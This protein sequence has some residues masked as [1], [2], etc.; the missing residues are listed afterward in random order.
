[1]YLGV[2]F[3]G[4]LGGNKFLGVGRMPLGCFLGMGLGSRAVGISMKLGDSGPT[5]RFVMELK[6]RCRD[7][8]SGSIV[9]MTNQSSIV[10]VEVVKRLKNL[11]VVN[12][13]LGGGSLATFIKFERVTL[14]E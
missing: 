5:R 2:P 13:G 6:V 1:M 8:A 7:R 9:G 4:R 10:G 3:S 14:C 12:E 11:A